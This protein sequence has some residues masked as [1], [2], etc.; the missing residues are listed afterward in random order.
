MPSNLSTWPEA[1]AFAVFCVS[2]FGTIAF[3]AWL[4]F[5]RP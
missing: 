1:F 4:V 3:I 2:I 5:R